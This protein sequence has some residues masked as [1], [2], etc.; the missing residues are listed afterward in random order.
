[1]SEE[2]QR[3]W[4]KRAV[5]AVNATFPKIEFDTWE[6]SDTWERCRRYLPQVFTCMDL[7]RQY[8]IHVAESA[9]LLDRA[10]FYLSSFARYE[11]A[12]LL[13][14]QALSICEPVLGPDHP[15]TAATFHNLA[16][17]Y[18]DQG[19]YAEAEPLYKRALAI[20]EQVLGPQHDDTAIS[21]DNLAMLYSDQGRYAEA[22][23]LYK[24]ALAI[25][26]QVLGP[27]DSG[28]PSTLANLA[29]LYLA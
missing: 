20:R 2:A 5:L 8:A 9:H 7:I 12:K 24:R 16:M 6:E 4:A 29:G 28:T 21:L 3:E 15:L 22:E 14:Q 27:H 10:G 18:H 26:E 1:M 11:E 23:P 17:N 13:L 25:C 19:H